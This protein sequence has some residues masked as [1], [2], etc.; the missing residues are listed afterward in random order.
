[1][2]EV[3]TSDNTKTWGPNSSALLE[4]FARELWSG[5]I[6]GPADQTLFGTGLECEDLFGILDTLSCPSDY[7]RV[8]LGATIGGIVCS[9]SATYPTPTASDWKG[10]TGRGSRKGTLAERLSVLTKS[11]GETTYPH[12]EFVEALIGFPILWTDLEDSAMPLIPTSPNGSG[13]EFI[14][15]HG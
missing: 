14:N 2:L 12:P 8:A 6:L 4:Y 11:E 9:C 7:D 1:M 15:H 10:S 3:F 5:R 13:D